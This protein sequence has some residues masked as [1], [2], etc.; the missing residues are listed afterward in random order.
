MYERDGALFVRGRNELAVPVNQKEDLAIHDALAGSVEPDPSKDP[1]LITTIRD[2]MDHRFMVEKQSA[3]T[4]RGGF[5][6]PLA[7]YYEASDLPGPDVRLRTPRG[8]LHSYCDRQSLMSLNFFQGSGV[9][10]GLS[11]PQLAQGIKS[12]S[13]QGYRFRTSIRRDRNS[14]DYRV[15]DELKGRPG[16]TFWTT[17]S[18]GLSFPVG[19]KEFTTEDAFETREQLSRRAM[20]LWPR[21]AMS[22]TE[23]YLES[24]FESGY[25]EPLRKARALTQLLEP[26]RGFDRAQEDYDTV[27]RSYPDLEEGTELFLALRQGGL[28]RDWSEQ[29][30]GWLKISVERESAQQRAQ[31]LLSVYDPESSPEEVLVRYI[32]QA[33]QSLS[34]DP[35]AALDRLTTRLMLKPDEVEKD[36]DIELE[37]DAILI[38]DTWLERNEYYLA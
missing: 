11:H 36:I 7:L 25:V 1:E 18:D 10:R 6:D 9:D 8:Q 34:E 31:V 15:Y 16:Q 27:V 38:G 22:D 17:A 12:R 23:D 33:A 37:G 20:A 35:T 26:R 5:M 29:V 24:V 32:E 4:R 21:E 14:A 30:L 13:D 28:P 2:L 3:Y 19:L